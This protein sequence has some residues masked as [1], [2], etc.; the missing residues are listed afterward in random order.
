MCSFAPLTLALRLHSL[1]RQPTLDHQSAN[2][3]ASFKHPR[4]TSTYGI[5]DGTSFSF[6]T[7]FSSL[8]HSFILAFPFHP[9][10]LHIH[11]TPPLP[12]FLLHRGPSRGRYGRALILAKQPAIGD[13]N[14]PGAPNQ[15]NHTKKKKKKTQP[16][17]GLGPS[18]TSRLLQIGTDDEKEK[19]KG[20]IL[21]L[22]SPDAGFNVLAFTCFM[23][24][25]KKYQQPPKRQQQQQP[26][27]LPRQ[28]R[29]KTKGKTKAISHG[30]PR[31]AHV[32]F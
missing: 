18:P 3:G 13:S 20:R 28:T 12:F 30:S 1:T 32:M 4:P 17:A 10:Q 9:A 16:W 21:R 29:R 8:I 15:S 14:S 27:P 31:N 11:T 23:L 19:K 5:A 2:A 22:L 6:R 26:A 25:A 24:D 7:F